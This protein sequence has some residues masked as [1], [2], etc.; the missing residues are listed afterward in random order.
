MGQR[1]K[2]AEHG[3]VEVM[4][5]HEQAAR[6]VGRRQA[7]WSALPPWS[8]LVDRFRAAGCRV[9]WDDELSVATSDRRNGRAPGGFADH[10]AELSREVSGD[11]D[12]EE[13]AS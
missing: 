7:N 5:M 11:R 3:K 13:E 9:L 2:R 1:A 12:R 4:G 6:D 10:L 8:D